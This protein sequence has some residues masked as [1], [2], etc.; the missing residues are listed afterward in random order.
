MQ[1]NKIV[2]LFP[3]LVVVEHVEAFVAVEAGVF[4]VSLAPGCHPGGGVGVAGATTHPVR[5][6]HVVHDGIAGSVEAIVRR[7]K[8][9]VGEDE[10]M[11]ATALVQVEV[12]LSQPNV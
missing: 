1:E 12:G 7:Q 9:H 4:R 3:V 2:D 8:P 11:L 10:Q 5:A 6:Q